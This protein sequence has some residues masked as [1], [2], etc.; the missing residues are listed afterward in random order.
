MS[1]LTPTAAPMAVDLAAI[2]GRQQVAWSIGDYAVIGGTLVSIAESLCEAVGVLD[3]A[4]QEALY[5][6]LTSLL[7]EMNVAGDASLAVP[8]AYLEAV[9]VKR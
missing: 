3:S 4:K 2:K 7:K 6:D 1:A 9:A 8:G 5:R